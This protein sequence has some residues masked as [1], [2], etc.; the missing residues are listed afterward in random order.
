MSEKFVYP[1]LRVGDDVEWSTEPSD[2]NIHFGKVMA[3][4]TQSCDIMAFT[5]SGL[6]PKENCWHA[7]D[8]RFY[9]HAQAI[10]HPDRGVF[11]VAKSEL[12]R[13]EVTATLKK[14]ME[15]LDALEAKPTRQAKVN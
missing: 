3:L 13:R 9:E 15:R 14:I 1:E 11:R 8:P 10:R 12:E 4:K 5:E 7:D 6:F 2:R